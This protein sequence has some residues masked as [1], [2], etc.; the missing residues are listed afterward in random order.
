MSTELA[1]IAF[2]VKFVPNMFNIGVS[3]TLI[4]NMFSDISKYLITYIN[5][6]SR[7]LLVSKAKLSFWQSRPP[8][9]QYNGTYNVKI[10]IRFIES[11]GENK[12][13]TLKL[14]SFKIVFLVVFSSLSRCSL[15]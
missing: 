8:L 11:L 1:P 7:H 6:V 9:P 3:H 2:I 14:L 12:T 10:V 4:G 5:T 13:R 15:N